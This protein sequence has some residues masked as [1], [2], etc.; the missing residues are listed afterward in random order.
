MGVPNTIGIVQSL[1]FMGVLFI[2]REISSQLFFLT[3]SQTA[4]EGNW[5]CYSGTVESGGTGH[6][7]KNDWGKGSF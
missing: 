2:R 7:M 1:T 3:H 4:S 5:C 6:L